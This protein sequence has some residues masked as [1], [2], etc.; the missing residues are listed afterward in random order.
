MCG[1]FDGNSCG[2]TL[3]QAIYA[4]AL[5]ERD[6]GLNY[7]W[8]YGY[9]ILTPTY[10]NQNLFTVPYSTRPDSQ[11]EDGAY[12]GGN[13]QGQNDC[14]GHCFWFTFDPGSNPAPSA[15]VTYNEIKNNRDLW[16]AYVGLTRG[17]FNWNSDANG[18]LFPDE[19]ADRLDD[20]EDPD[21][22]CGQPMPS[23]SFTPSCMFNNTN[24]LDDDWDIVY[25]HFDVDDDNDGVW[26]YFEVDLNDDFDDDDWELHGV[27]EP[28]YFTGTNCEDSDDDG[29]DTDP[30][31][32]G[33][34]QAVWDKGVLGQ[35]LMVPEYYD[36]DN[37]YD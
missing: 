19:V 18:N 35:G 26:D 36:V 31:G 4:G 3:Y 17:L 29:L 10:S 20:F 8:L 27:Y 11:H 13:S 21:I 2:T 12:D 9:P 25:D 15:A 1:T 5:I 6:C 16:I 14:D 30:D 28:Y 23:F 7:A 33:W 24:D 37:D 22:D 34:Y 32:D